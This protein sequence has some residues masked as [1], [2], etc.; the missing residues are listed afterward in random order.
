MKVEKHSEYIYV[1]ANLSKGYR[2][3]ECKNNIQWI[4]QKK[5]LSKSYWRSR[6]YCL[7]KN[8]IIAVLDKLCIDSTSLSKLPMHFRSQ[9]KTAQGGQMGFNEDVVA[10]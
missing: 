3:I 2:L 4:L 10:N 8:G 9:F 6:K 1:V 5:A 7:T